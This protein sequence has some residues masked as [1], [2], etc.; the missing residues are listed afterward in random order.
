MP[1]R[2][3]RLSVIAVA[4]TLGLIAFATL[5]PVRITVPTPILCLACGDLGGVD[6]IL[7]VLL[8]VPLGMSLSAAGLSSHRATLVALAVSL[9]VESLQ[10]SLI[11]GRDSSL[12]DLLTN[13]VGGALGASMAQHWRAVILPAP[14]AARRLAL[15]GAV[16]ALL[17]MAGTAA[18]L[19]PSVPPIWLWGQWTPK[20]QQFETYTGRVTDFKVGAVSVPYGIVLEWDAL[21]RSILRRDAVAHLE[22]ESGNRTSSIAAIARLV[23]EGQEI[24]LIGARGDAVIYRA[25]LRAADS[26]L[27]T[28]FVSLPGALGGSGDMVRVEASLEPDGWHVSATSPRG[29]FAR[30]VPFSVALGWTFVLPFEH[31]L[32]PA[33]VLWSAL[34]LAALAFP[35]AFWGAQASGRRTDHRGRP[36]DDSEASSS[37]RGQVITSLGAPSLMIAAGLIVIP[38]LSHFGPTSPYEWFGFVLGSALGVASAAALRRRTASMSLQ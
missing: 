34:W 12:S 20:R 36:D 24:L 3:T 38:R 21:T 35:A 26:R 31:A 37:R 6:V 27:R 10:F 9:L 29:T 2:S 11:P 14:R 23:G 15:A 1:R 13:T 5:R 8:F 18:L 22:F 16:A 25:R 17:T 19:Q 28:P 32:V 7:N 4:G 33:D 30:H